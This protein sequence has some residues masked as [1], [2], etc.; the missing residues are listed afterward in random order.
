MV[1]FNSLTESVDAI[2]KKAKQEANAEYQDVYRTWNTQSP[3]ALKTLQKLVNDTDGTFQFYVDDEKIF[4]NLTKSGNLLENPG[5]NEQEKTLYLFMKDG[6]QGYGLYAAYMTEE[7]NLQ[8]LERPYDLLKYLKEKTAES[9]GFS[10]EVYWE[11]VA[12]GL[13]GTLQDLACMSKNAFKFHVTKDKIYTNI[14][15]LGVGALHERPGPSEAGKVIYIAVTDG[16]YG[17]GVC[18]TYDGDKFPQRH[19]GADSV[20]FYLTRDVLYRSAAL[21]NTPKPL[22]CTAI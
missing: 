3:G 7:E 9:K 2:W 14:P 11:T 5:P 17:R 21:K 15:P 20:A 12:P 16:T 1:H 19:D 8:K 4:T 22:I 6:K 10:K 18:T 13:L